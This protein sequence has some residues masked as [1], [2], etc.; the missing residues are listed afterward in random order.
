MYN[1]Y[2]NKFQTF[3]LTVRIIW[4]NLFTYSWFLTTKTMLNAPNMLVTMKK[5]FWLERIQA[6]SENTL[7][8]YI[9]VIWTLSVP[10]CSDNWNSIVHIR[11]GT[12]RVGYRSRF[13]TTGQDIHLICN[14]EHMAFTNTYWIVILVLY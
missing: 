8:Q 5:S 6:F 11:D 13:W 14:H 9:S 10:T 2:I 1:V 7:I 4:W 12:G 3:W